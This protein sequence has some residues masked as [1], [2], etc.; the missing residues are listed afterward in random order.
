MKH[1]STFLLCSCVFAL[2][3][4]AAPQIRA[5]DGDLPGTVVA[6]FSVPAGMSPSEIKSVIVAAVNARKYNVKETT[7]NKV[8]ANLVHRDVDAT[9]TFT[10]DAKTLTLYCAAWET[11]RGV[12]GKPAT[13]TRWI[14][15]L[16]LDINTQFA[17]RSGAK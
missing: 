5:A 13:P 4:L 1:L 12:R 10:W 8:V 7:D 14:E 9:M 2:F 16:K 17:A 15:N 3:A 11:K 6:T